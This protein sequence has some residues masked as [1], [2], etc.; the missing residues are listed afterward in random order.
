MPPLDIHQKR[1]GEDVCRHQV[2]MAV[3]QVAKRATSNLMQ[4]GK[5]HPVSSAEVPDGRVLARGHDLH[6]R[7]VVLPPLEL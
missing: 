3:L 6:C 7:T 4:E 2:R 5:I 1:L